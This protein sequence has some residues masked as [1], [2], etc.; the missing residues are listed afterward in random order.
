MKKNFLKGKIAELLELP[1]EY[2]CDTVKVS[3]TGFEEFEIINYKSLVEY[4][5]GYIKLYT[6]EK[7]ITIQGENLII[8]SITDES[9]SVTG[10]IKGV[11]FD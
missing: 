11:V 10:N 3:I 6:G 9:L 7:L 5:A 4:E 1:K 2:V 8:K